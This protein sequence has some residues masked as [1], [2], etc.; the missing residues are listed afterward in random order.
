[1]KIKKTKILGLVLALIM[2]FTNLPFGMGIVHAEAGDV[3]IETSFPDENFRNYVKEKF[4]TAEPK[5]VL[6]QAELDE[7]KKINVRGMLIYKLEGIEHFKNLEQLICESN[8]LSSLD[9]SNNKVLRNLNCSNNQLKS[10]DLSNNKDL[11]FLW[12]NDNQISELDTKNKD[13][14]YLYCQ[15]NRLTSL[16]VKDRE[17]TRWDASN[18]VYD[19]TVI[20]E[21]REYKYSDLPGQF[22]KD[23][24]SDQTGVSFGKN[25]LIVNSDSVRK[26]KYTYKVFEKS[27]SRKLVFDVILNI[28]YKNSTVAVRD[29]EEPGTV[30]I[31]RVRVTF[32]AG[33]GNTIEGTN[34][35]K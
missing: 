27:A 33:E 19:I 28:K 6:S 20:K 5:G 9:L 12:C 15:N 23:K 14:S 34:R 26:A 22:N 30:P 16:D 18:Q 13:L 24:V 31:G 1:M 10:L 7:V 2:F 4:D 3:N 29:S 11:R 25:A 32:D 8:P 17:L 35:Y 21:I